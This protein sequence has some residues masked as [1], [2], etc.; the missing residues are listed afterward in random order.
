MAVPLHCLQ[1]EDSESDA[2]LVFRLLKKAEF[3]VHGER[4][5]S[6]SDLRKALARQ[7]W[8]VIIA[9]YHLPGFD[10]YKALSILQETGLDIPF[11]GISGKVGNEIAAEIMQ[12]GAADYMTKDELTRLVPAIK[13]ELREAERRRR[14]KIADVAL[15][16]ER[17]RFTSAL[18]GLAEAVITTDADGSIVTSNPIA[19]QITCWSS[20]EATGKSVGELVHLRH[21]DTNNPVPS[22]VKT[23]LETGAPL[24]A[25]EANMIDRQ[26]YERKIAY[27]ALPVKNE[28]NEILGTVLVFR[29]VA[30]EERQ[31]DNL[32]SSNRLRSI[33]IVASQIA[34]DFSNFLS[35]I[36]G[37]IELAQ[38]YCRR[39]NLG[40]AMERL[41]SALKVFNNAKNMAFQLISI[42]QGGKP[43][44]KAMA[45]GPIIYHEAR[46]FLRRDGINY[47][48]ELPEDL[49]QCRIDETQ[50]SLVFDNIFSNV[51]QIMA[52]GGTICIKA[53]NHE[54]GS[55][56]MPPVI[57]GRALRI[58]VNA[59]C[60]GIEPDRLPRAM[61]PYDASRKCSESSLEICSATSIITQHGGFLRIE[62]QVAGVS[63]FIYLP[64]VS[65]K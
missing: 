10:A 48:T 26:G 12:R 39:K 23:L 3:D 34:H 58:T 7:H 49:W 51:R 47:E 64:A 50:M 56:D 37:N 33:G 27:G 35:I 21:P 9:D 25:G 31:N 40:K 19:E 13:R 28:D 2:A 59:S 65:E 4:V 55:P 30:D 42:S 17:E 18:R 11:I 20:A 61:D 16:N 52:S 14:H 6:A 36:M 63:Y 29:E 15:Q 46:K 32:L 62:P 45:I 60:P 54:A 1:V 53:E 5:E 22:P 38:E 44:V 8:D 41:D 24:V 57:S 43:L